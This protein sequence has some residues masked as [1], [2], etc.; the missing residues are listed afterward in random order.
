VAIARPA[1]RRPAAP[2]LDAPALAALVR[3]AQENAPRAFEDLVRATYEDVFALA[4][5][6]LGNEEDACDVV[7][8][9]YIRA[10]RG[11]AGF[12]G[13]AAVGTWL[14]RITAN[15]ASSHRF[16][17]QRLRRHDRLDDVAALPDTRPVAD[18]EGMATTAIERAEVAAAL[19]LLPARLRA[20][21]VLRDIYDLP[22][23]AIAT[24][25]GISEGAAKVRLHR[26]RKRL[27]EDLFRSATE[28]GRV[29]M[30]SVETAFADEAAR[31]V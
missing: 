21:I 4:L 13:D 20:V 17:L 24:E 19:R 9:A 2:R 5:R 16:R 27:R 6:L 12:R 23:G 31:A 14:H 11:L 28:S 25:L 3:A 29:S 15:C 7:Q 22:H 8:E 30:G 10:Y 1:S 18:P 26:A